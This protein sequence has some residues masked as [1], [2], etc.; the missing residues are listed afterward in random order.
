MIDRHSRNLAA[1][2]LRAAK[3]GK[4]TNYEIEDQW[5]KSGDKALIYIAQRI[6]LC[7]DDLKKDLFKIDSNDEET[8]SLIERCISFL[9][10]EEEYQWPDYNFDR[11]GLIFWIDLTKSKK[12]KTEEWEGFVESADFSKWP[13]FVNAVGGCD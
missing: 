6:W 10:S 2:I 7:Y 13:F 11:S 3:S 8:R 4:I 1:D 5:P 9:E 12:A